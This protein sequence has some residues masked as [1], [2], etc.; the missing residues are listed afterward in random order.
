MFGVGFN[1]RFTFSAPVLNLPP[2]GILQ[3]DLPFTYPN[4]V[5][6][7]MATV[8]PGFSISFTQVGSTPK[9]DSYTAIRLNSV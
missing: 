3:P 6:F 9:S 7:T 4:Q 8:A 1:L 5:E 2:F